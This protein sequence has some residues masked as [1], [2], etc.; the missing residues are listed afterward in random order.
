VA[1]FYLS[2]RRPNDILPSCSFAEIVREMPKS[3]AVYTIYAKRVP[4]SD[5]SNKH[6]ALT[7]SMS[8]GSVGN[9]SPNTHRRNA[10]IV[11]WTVDRRYSDFYDFHNIVRDNVSQLHFAIITCWT[12]SSVWQLHRSKPICWSVVPFWVELKAIKWR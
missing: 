7:K 2:S 11:E 12:P 1:D 6:P 4:A 5:P 9:H 8:N 3:F 10:S